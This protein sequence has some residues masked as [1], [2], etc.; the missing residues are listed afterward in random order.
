M[1]KI[2]SCPVSPQ[3]PTH[4]FS[5][6]AETFDK[7]LLIHVIWRKGRDEEGEGKFW[8]LNWC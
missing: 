7:G 5:L 4:S 8:S 1:K 3:L 6:H 2:T